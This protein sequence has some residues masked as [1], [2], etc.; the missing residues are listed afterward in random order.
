MLAAAVLHV[1]LRY[2]GPGVGFIPWRLLGDGGADEMK[3]LLVILLVV[4]VAAVC[5]L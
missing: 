1:V 2:P 4:F 3:K 5:T